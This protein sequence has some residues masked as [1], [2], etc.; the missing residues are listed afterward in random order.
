MRSEQIKD[1][2]N[3]LRLYVVEHKATSAGLNIVA[4][5]GYSAHPLTFLPR[6]RHLVPSAL[7]DDFVLK[8]SERQQDVER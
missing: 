2:P 5:H 4:Q 8:L 1:L 7:A 3:P 6:G